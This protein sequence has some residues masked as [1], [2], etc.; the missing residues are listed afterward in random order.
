[1]HFPVGIFPGKKEKPLTIPQNRAHAHRHA[2][3]QVRLRQ[4]QTKIWLKIEPM[5]NMLFF[6]LSH[7]LHNPP[8]SPPPPSPLTIVVFYAMDID[9]SDIDPK[10]NPFSFTKFKADPVAKKTK[11]RKSKSGEMGSTHLSSHLRGWLLW[12]SES[13]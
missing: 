13:L 10:D 3:Y 12:S 11:D 8:T 1:M 4:I 2:C 6:N 7:S 9:L 5:K